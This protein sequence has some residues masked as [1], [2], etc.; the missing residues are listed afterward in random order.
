MKSALK[1]LS[2]FIYYVRRGYRL[3][4]AWDMA[5]VTL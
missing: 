4:Q 1:F 3:R 2:D 5:K